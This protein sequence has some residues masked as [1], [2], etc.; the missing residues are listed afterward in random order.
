MKKFWLGTFFVLCWG[1]VANAAQ[2]Q[3]QSIRFEHGDMW[4]L[5]TD[6]TVK[7]AKVIHLSHD[8]SDS[9][10]L[11]VLLS[12]VP[13]TSYYAEKLQ[14][15]GNI[16]ANVMAANF[17]WPFIQRFSKESSLENRLVSFNEV[18]VGNTLS[19]GALVTVPTP[20][21][22]IFI[23]AQTFYVDKPNYYIVGSVVTR[24]DKGVM[25]HSAEYAKRIDR[26]YQLIK[27]VSV[28]Y[29]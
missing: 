15:K 22:R 2:Y 24:I 19:S 5:L 27:S 13:K 21:D 20:Q 11:S 16:S 12:F 18:L 3:W 6:R 23:S 10:P 4:S 1:S 9:Y 26:A 7:G 17:S 29:D 8:I 14:L 25:R 28:D